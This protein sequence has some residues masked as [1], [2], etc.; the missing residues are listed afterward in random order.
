[1]EESAAKITRRTIYAFLQHYQHLTTAPPLLV[2]PF[3]ASI[4]LSQALAA[5]TSPPP[6][7]IIYAGFHGGGFPA[8]SQFVSLLNNI[9]LSQTIFALSIA[10]AKI[11]IIQAVILQKKSSPLTFSSFVVLYK[12]LVLT[13]A[14]NSVL[15]LLLVEAAILSQLL[16]GFNSHKAIGLLVARAIFYCFRAY[17]GVICNLALVAAA[18]ENRVGFAA[19]YRACLMSWARKSTAISLNLAVNLSILAVERLFRYR[20]TRAYRETGSFGPG[21]AMEGL[22]IAY[23]YSLLIVL[24]TVA[25][26]L[27]YKSC[28]GVDNR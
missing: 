8:R 19:I 2:L 22:F 3:T 13:Q 7:L 15:L 6:Y 27:F 4:L 5:V 1:M 12:R 18:A 17:A 21:L 9:H 20:I 26:C 25:S 28:R 10:V 16:L 14:C 23:L 24:H 11:L